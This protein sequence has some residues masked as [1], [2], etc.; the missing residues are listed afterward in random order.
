MRAPG[1]VRQLVTQVGER[2]GFPVRCRAERGPD[3]GQPVRGGKPLGDERGMEPGDFPG[4]LPDVIYQRG[5]GP[6]ALTAGMHAGQLE[7]DRGEDFVIAGRD[8][9]LVS[10]R[11]RMIVQWASRLL[12]V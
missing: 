12:S 1:I 9:R 4:E 11:V 5:N 2:V 3:S 6:V 10:V 8:C 7:R